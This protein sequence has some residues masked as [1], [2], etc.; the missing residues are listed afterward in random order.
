MFPE[1]VLFGETISLYQPVTTFGQLCIFLW[2]FFNLREYKDISTFS[3]IPGQRIKNEK[4]KKPVDWILALIGITVIFAVL[5]S[6]SMPI[7]PKISMLFLGDK[8]DNF[9]YNIFVLPLGLLLFGSIFFVSPFKFSDY[10]APGISIALI[11]FKIACFCCG[12]CNGV[13]SNSFG[14]LN[15]VTNQK[16]VPV[17]LIEIICAVIMLI[18]ILLVRR[19]KERKPGILYP[20]FMVMYCASRFVSE[21]WRGDYPDVYGPLKGYHIQ[22]IIGFVEGLIILFIALKWGEKVSAFYAAKKESI[23]KKFEKNTP[24]AEEEPEE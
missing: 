14:M 8:S 19:K 4:V 1:L 13:P 12:C 5:F 9:F 10:I 20:L 2:I 16:E 6:L 22:C 18:I 7:T 3:Q 11:I 21:F 24:V 17:Q 15:H 23:L